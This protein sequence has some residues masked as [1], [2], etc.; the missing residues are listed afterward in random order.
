MANMSKS[1]N[2]H[3]DAEKVKAGLK[4]FHADPNKPTSA[5]SIKEPRAIN[6]IRRQ[7][8]DLSQPSVAI[9]S[10]AVKGDLVAQKTVWKGKPEEKQEVLD[11]D[12][13]ASFEMMT[14]DNGKEVE[15]LVTYDQ[16]SKQQIE[17]AKWVLNQEVALRKAAEDSKLRKLEAALKEK[18][19]RDEGALKPS[20]EENRE[21]AKEFGG[22]KRID[23]SYDPQ[24]DEDDD[25]D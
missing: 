22:P 14:L 6:N 11:N 25:D 4:K 21:K 3:Y 1:K 2:P 19:A 17:I 10:K 24:W 7:F 13:S 23:I 9:V 16:V 20:E 8:T 5:G 15:V 18:K 12:P